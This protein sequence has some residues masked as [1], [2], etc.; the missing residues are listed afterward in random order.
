[1]VAAP[2]NADEIPHGCLTYA[3]GTDIDFLVPPEVLDEE[4]QN[5]A[6]GRFPLQGELL[7]VTWLDDEESRLRD[8]F[9]PEPG[10]G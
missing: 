1:M 4:L 10:R 5:W 9:P 3:D 6:R 7:V 8:S 2:V